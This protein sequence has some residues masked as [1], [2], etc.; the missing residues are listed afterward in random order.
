MNPKII[1]SPQNEC[2][3]NA[4][5]LKD[6]KHRSESGRFLVEGIKQVLEISGYWKIDKL[7][8]A[9]NK[10]ALIEQN[11]LSKSCPQIFI[12]SQ[13]AA[14]KLSS[15]KTTQGIFAEVEKRSFDIAEVLE[16]G[17]RF[18][19]LEKISDPANIAAVIRC[20]DAFAFD[21]VFVSCGSADIYSDKVL[22]ASVGSFFHLPVIDEIGVLDLLQ[23]AR[24]LSIRIYASSL[25][26][27]KNIESLRP[28]GKSMIL[29]GAEAEGLSDETLK[30][31]DEV[32]RIE[33]LGGAQSLN[34]A[35]AAAIMMYEFRRK[36]EN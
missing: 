4:A 19:L 32:F 1:K 7:F 9:E 20:A 13:N 33:M 21:A 27:S 12:V 24:D 28:V 30:A 26:A 18:V 3:K 34:A 14:D 10:G 17:S 25:G 15:V 29:I 11:D 31:A 6:K 22:R 16:K 36:T 35:C 23:K 2:I 8:I 5:L